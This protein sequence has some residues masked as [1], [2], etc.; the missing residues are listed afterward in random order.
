MPMDISS[1]LTSQ[2]SLSCSLFISQSL[3][4]GQSLC[5]PSDFFSI[6][7]HALGDINHSSGFKYYLHATT[8]KFISLSPELYFPVPNPLQPPHCVPY[9]T[10]VIRLQN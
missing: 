4:V 5:H 2:Q 8:S 9:N 1:H 3:D 10:L 7:P 6:C